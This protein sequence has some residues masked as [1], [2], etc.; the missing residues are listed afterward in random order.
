MWKLETDKDK[1]R[2]YINSVTNSRCVQSQCYVDKEGNKWY[3][4]NDLS[5]I[6]YTRQFAATKISSLYQLGVTKDDLDSHITGLKNILR[7]QDK[8]KYEKAFA[9]VLDFESKVQNASDAVKQM[10]SL[11][12]V[13]FT[14]NDEPIDSF[15]GTLQAKK[16]AL[17]EADYDM[18]AFFLKRQIELTESYLISSNIISQIA[19]NKQDE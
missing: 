9:N 4:F 12:C 6:P 11:V 2:I 13:Y 15:E 19:L 8:D 1:Q 7:S 16:I 18:H 10:S 17:L 14:I 5:A 3:S